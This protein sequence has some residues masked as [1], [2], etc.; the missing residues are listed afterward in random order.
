M[1]GMAHPALHSQDGGIA[2]R[3]EHDLFFFC[4]GKLG[5][6]PST[7]QILYSLVAGSQEQKHDSK[8]ALCVVM[9]TS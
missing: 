8:S 6:T 4:C 2:F 9:K 1:N 3:A 5:I 7:Q